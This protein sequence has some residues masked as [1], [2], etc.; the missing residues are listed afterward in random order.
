M[1]KNKEMFFSILQMILLAATIITFV[2]LAIKNS[3]VYWWVAAYFFVNL[4]DGVR[5]SF[6]IEKDQ[7]EEIA[8]FEETI[9]NINKK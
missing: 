9:K 2:H 7:K 1:I 8:V 3:G 6:T 4:L 5:T